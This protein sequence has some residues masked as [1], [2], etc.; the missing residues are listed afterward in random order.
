LSDTAPPTF[1][2]M[3]T[4]EILF[5]VCTLLIIGDLVRSWI[6]EYRAQGH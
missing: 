1:E 6:K 4:G 2:R 3:M 5:G